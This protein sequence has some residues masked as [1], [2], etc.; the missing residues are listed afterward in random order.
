MCD[1][2]DK[3]IKYCNS[4]TCNEC[5]RRKKACIM[6]YNDKPMIAYFDDT[7]ANDLHE[8]IDFYSNL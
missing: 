1:I 5:P 2:I 4:T 8:M 3:A 7:T 6:S